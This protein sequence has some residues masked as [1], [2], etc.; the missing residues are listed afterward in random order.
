MSP[1]PNLRG[2]QSSAGDL[3]LLRALYNMQAAELDHAQREVHRLRKAYNDYKS[4]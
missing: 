3:M 1:A 4:R 2:Y